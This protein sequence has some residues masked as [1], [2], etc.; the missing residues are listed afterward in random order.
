[1]LLTPGTKGDDAQGRD[2]GLILP[3]LR[4]FRFVLSLSRNSKKIFI[5]PKVRLRV[6]DEYIRETL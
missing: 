5:K 4:A 3:H 2:P 1:M 6:A